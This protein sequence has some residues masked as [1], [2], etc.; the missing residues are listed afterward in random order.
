M[1]ATAESRPSGRD[2]EHARHRREILAAAVRLFA[3]HGYHETTMQLVAQAADVSVGYLYKHFHWGWNYGDMKI[4]A[5]HGVKE[6]RP[7]SLPQPT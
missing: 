2:R 7:D 4:F 6:D 5:F 3:E 1:V